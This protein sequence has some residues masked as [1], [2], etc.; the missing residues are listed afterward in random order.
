MERKKMKIEHLAV[1]Y[2]S[3]EEADKFYIEFV[4]MKKYD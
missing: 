2:N 4:E 1:G 3:E